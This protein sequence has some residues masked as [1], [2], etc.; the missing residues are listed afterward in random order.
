MGYLF[1]ASKRKSN[2][3]GDEMGRERRRMDETATENLI[4]L[5]FIVMRI[6]HQRVSRGISSVAE[7]ILDQSK[8]TSEKTDGSLTVFAV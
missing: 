5:S 6:L 4:I 1:A 3:G 8:N 2:L 7:R